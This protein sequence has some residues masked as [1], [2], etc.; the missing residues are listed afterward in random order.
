M[1]TVLTT[2]RLPE[3]IMKALDEKAREEGLDR[4]TILRKL[5]EES[6]KRW[7]IEKAANMYKQGKI[8]LSKAAKIAEL[9]VDE[10]M[11][12]LARRG[13]KSDL[14][15]EEYKESLATALKLFEVKEY[16]TKRNH[17]PKN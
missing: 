15:L 4:T 16:P 1:K 11:E 12:E 10:T 14:T 6:I 5:L 17:E 13:I 9:P 7:K 3:K 2:V 8:S